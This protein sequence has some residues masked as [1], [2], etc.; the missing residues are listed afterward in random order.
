M[1]TEIVENQAEK[2]V[3]KE[4]GCD[5]MFQGKKLEELAL[6]FRVF[7]RVEST[8][9]YVIQKMAPYIDE[10]GTRIVT[11]EALLKDPIEFTTKLLEFK[12]EMDDMVEFSFKNDIRFQKNR[13]VQF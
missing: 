7:R 2:L 6:L 1:Q 13:D 11:D 9:K 5:A 12:K 3:D 8:L 4:S 10:R